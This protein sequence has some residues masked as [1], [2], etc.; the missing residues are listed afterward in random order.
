[1]IRGV[2]ANRRIDVILSLLDFRYSK[3]ESNI[4]SGLLDYSLN[5]H[6]IEFCVIRGLEEFCRDTGEFL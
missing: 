3:L 5:D 6:M 2:V 4:L 1:M